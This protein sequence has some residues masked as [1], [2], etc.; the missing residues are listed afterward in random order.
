MPPRS[1]PASVWKDGKTD[2]R[3]AHQQVVVVVGPA[4]GQPDRDVCTPGQWAALGFS[5]VSVGRIGTDTL[6][7]N[8]FWCAGRH[9]HDSVH[10]EREQAKDV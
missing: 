6:E 8:P 3:L 9:R 10:R 1:S 5:I 4:D 7:V 2:Q